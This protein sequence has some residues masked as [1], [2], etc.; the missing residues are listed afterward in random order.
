MV[1]K[2]AE[3]VVIGS[4]CKPASVSSEEESAFEE[5]KTFASKP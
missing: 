3:G 2:L 4:A 1:G 5:L